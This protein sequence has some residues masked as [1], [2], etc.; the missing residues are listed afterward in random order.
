MRHSCKSIF[1]KARRQ[2]AMVL[3][4]VFMLAALTTSA[5]AVQ[6]ALADDAISRY[7]QTQSS[8]TQDYGTNKNKSEFEN[9]RDAK[10]NED[11]QS[12]NN[13]VDGN[14]FKNSALTGMVVVFLFFILGGVVQSG[15]TREMKKEFED[16]EKRLNENA[17]VAGMD[18]DEYMDK[19]FAKV[20]EKHSGDNVVTDS[21]LVD[22]SP[23][24]DTENV[25]ES[26]EKKDDTTPDIEEDPN[27]V[28]K[29][30]QSEDEDV[31]DSATDSSDDAGT[32]NGEDKSSSDF[33]NSMDNEKKGKPEPAT[34]D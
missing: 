22:K 1:T 21:A 28:D 6:P 26:D 4:F 12:K 15:S 19:L 2:S 11:S 24:P 10:T 29:I 16:A 31:E 14:Q 30:S 17:R 13:K 18:P 32:S 9:R 20:K 33:D 3:A 23:E 5:V 27:G 34:V 7:S 25:S 8:T